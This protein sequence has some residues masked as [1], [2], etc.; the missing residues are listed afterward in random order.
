MRARIASY[1]QKQKKNPKSA[2]KNQPLQ[3]SGNLKQMQS[4]NRNL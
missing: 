1:E 3:V 4:G 2:Y